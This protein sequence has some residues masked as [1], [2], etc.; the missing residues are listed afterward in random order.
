MAD[1]PAHVIAAE[2]EQSRP[3]ILT[4]PA[5]PPNGPRPMRSRRGLRNGVRQAAREPRNR[6]GQGRRPL[7]GGWFRFTPLFSHAEHRSHR[8]SAETSRFGLCRPQAGTSEP[9]G[10]ERALSVI[11]GEGRAVAKLQAGRAKGPEAKASPLPAIS[12]TLPV[13]RRCA[14]GSR[15][16]SCAPRVRGE[17]PPYGVRSC[18]VAA[19]QEAR[20]WAQHRPALRADFKGG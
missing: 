10:R 2:Q 15:S 18:A 4:G 12:L 16:G 3:A 8:L 1:I 13:T 17:P 6:F 19:L 14:L 7:S 20:L 9:G 11:A 5:Q